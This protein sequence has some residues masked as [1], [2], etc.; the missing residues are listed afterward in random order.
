[1]EV[2]SERIDEIEGFRIRHVGPYNEVG[3]GT[4]PGHSR[5]YSSPGRL[6]LAALASPVLV[7]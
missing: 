3:P 1:M 6:W 5:P 4:E 2:R 7:S